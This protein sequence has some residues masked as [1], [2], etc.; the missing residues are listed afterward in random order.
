MANLKSKKTGTDVVHFEQPRLPYHEAVE[1]RFG[2]S[3]DQWKT[4]VEATFPSAK[5]SGA[6]ILALSYCKARNL[7]PFKK[8]VHI[9]PIWDPRQNKYVET[10]WPGIAE[11][12]TTAFRTGQYAGCDAP[13]FGPNNDG[14]FAGK[15]DVWE[16][17]ERTGTKELKVSVF[18]PEWCRITVYRM[19]QGQR[20]KFVG[21]KVYW[22][23]SY[24]TI[25]KTDV[26]NE[27]WQT[28]PSGQ[29][30][31]VAE[32][33]A[34]R[35]AFPEELG[36]E[37]TAEEATSRTFEHHQLPPA[38]V[39]EV[40]E[41]TNQSGPP[42]A[43]TEEPQDGREHG[44]AVRQPEAEKTR[45]GPPAAPPAPMSAENELDVP[46]FLKRDA[47]EPDPEAEARDLT[48][49]V[50]DHYAAVQTMQDFDEVTET[51]GADID[52]LGRA[53]RQRCEDARDKAFERLR[54]R[55][56]AD[57]FAIPDFKDAKGIIDW[58]HRLAGL[59]T[60]AESGQRAVDA[61][62]AAKEVRAGMLSA[63]EYDDTLKVM[64]AAGKKLS[65]KL[66]A[67]P[68]EGPPPAPPE[69]SKPV[70]LNR[71]A[72]TWEEFSAQ[73]HTLL[74]AAKLPADIRKWLLKHTDVRQRL[75]PSQKVWE[76]GLKREAV[77]RIDEL[78]MAERA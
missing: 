67:E 36:G 33:G 5:T 64:R 70:E 26:P 19:I 54:S 72:E 58:T 69:T 62:K 1:D 3:K 66:K 55:V 52:N 51:F 38:V 73:V 74:Q 7:D 6:V 41:I 65:E 37:I 44:E 12:R 68:E 4:L 31:K 42:P 57:P 46:D 34:L 28:R 11:L 63:K 48:K 8:P 43:P 47:P 9:V 2:I 18:Y 10:V 23:E 60:D 53:Y 71:E 56:P 27:M 17:G 25:G 21:P 30:E 61:F 20:C 49:H 15:V 40:A 35:R 16:R 78:E 22:E 39:A 32:A 29:L 76:D 45:P 75:Q 24:A 14:E 50:E 77:K 59:M 13:E